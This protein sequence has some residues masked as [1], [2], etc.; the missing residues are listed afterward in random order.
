[1]ATQT[2]IRHLQEVVEDLSICLNSMGAGAASL[3]QGS[4]IRDIQEIIE[5]LATCLSSIE[6]A[7]QSLVNFCLERQ[8]AQHTYLHLLRKLAGVQDFALATAGAKVVKPLTTNGSEQCSW[9][10]S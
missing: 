1:M 6:T 10:Q 3:M 7:A 9:F 8:E 5:D 4:Q 2:S